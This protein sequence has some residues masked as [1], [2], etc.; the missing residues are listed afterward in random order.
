MVGW[1]DGMIL[2]ELVG[3]V[4]HTRECGKLT[5]VRR[6]TEALPCFRGLME[7]LSGQTCSLASLLDFW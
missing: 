6:V 5:L 2:G 4:L 3:F 7:A 1:W